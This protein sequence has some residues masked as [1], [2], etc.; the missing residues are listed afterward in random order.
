MPLTTRE[1]L[2]RECRERAE[3]L[4][5]NWDD[6]APDCREEAIYAALLKMAEDTRQTDCEAA[7]R[8]CR[9]DH[10]QEPETVERVPHHIERQYV[11]NCGTMEG[12]VHGTSWGAL[13][14]CG[15][16]DIRAAAIERLVKGDK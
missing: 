11:P 2:E 1:E 7:C 14:E 10:R 15:A 12:F 6:L 9:G 3:Q 16:S 5:V 4:Y 13:I 8:F